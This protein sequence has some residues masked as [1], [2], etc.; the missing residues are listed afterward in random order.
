MPRS[1]SNSKKNLLKTE[2]VAELYP[3][4]TLVWCNNAEV[5][6][7]KLTENK[8]DIEKKDPRGRTPLMLAI[9]LN[10]FDSALVLLEHGANCNT[11]TN[12]WSAV[13]EAT[14]TGNRELIKLIIE[15]RNYQRKCNQFG[16]IPQLLLKLKEAPDFYVE[17]KWEFTSW[18][19]LVTRMCPSDTY[20]VF[21]QGSK[22]RIDSTL[23][24]FEELKWLR[25]NSSL[26]FQANDNFGAM[27][28][29]DHN[30]QKVYYDRR[31]FVA[32]DDVSQVKDGSETLKA[33]MTNPIV[34]SYIDTEKIS[35]ERSKSGVWGWRQDKTET[36]NGYPCKVFSASNV[37]LITKTRMEHLQP[38][39]KDKF[40]NNGNVLQNILG[41][42]EKDEDTHQECQSSDDPETG[43]N[44]TLH[45]YF[46]EGFDLQGRDIGTPKDLSTK[47]RKFKANLWLC[48]DYPLSLQ[49]QIMPIVDLMATSS[50][51]FAK[52]KDFI[53]MQL[54]AGF[55]VKI[56]IPLFHVLNASVTFDNIFAAER[57]V[58]GVTMIR[59]EERLMCDIDESLFEP[60][61]HYTFIDLRKRS[62]EEEDDLLQYALQNSF[63]GDTEYD[64]DQVDVW[65]VLQA[66]RSRSP[67]IPAD[68][69]EREL[70]RAIEE[71]LILSYGAAETS[72]NPAIEPNV[73]STEVVPYNNEDKELLTALSL[74][75]KEQTEHEKNLKIEEEML[76]QAL[77]ISINDK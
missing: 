59:D 26:I 54:P 34:S 63:I 11:E 20:R 40:Q 70:Q 36:I 22:V 9:T 64:R 17:M 53:E 68:D 19:P 13:Q 60:P 62:L 33:R 7:E 49:E 61:S 46:T 67:S 50:S 77:R 31:S 23:M 52:L 27:I 74:S 38:E 5:L 69:E 14:V 65:E 44:V 37:E 21:K 8:D 12:G 73:Q 4:H 29:L 76:Q 41:F 30:T 2:E 18:M 66:Q 58:T 25:G 24:G 42:G 43:G 28:E 75:I 71:S 48:K 72:S 35:F 32:P 51:N 39:D 47:I 57:P 45:E 15:R 56:E 16:G 1:A 3:L 55:P 6:H 10:H